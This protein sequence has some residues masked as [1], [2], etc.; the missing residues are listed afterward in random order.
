MFVLWFCYNFTNY[1]IKQNIEVQ[2]PHWISPLWQSMLYNNQGFNI[3]ETCRQLWYDHLWFFSHVTFSIT[4]SSQTPHMVDQ[5]I[6]ASVLLEHLARSLWEFSCS[7]RL[8]LKSWV[9]WTTP[10]QTNRSTRQNI[11]QSLHMATQPHGKTFPS[12][13]TRIR[14]TGTF[15]GSATPQIH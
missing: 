6:P 10:W 3:S 9:R 4:S 11:P 5:P 7:D 8:I 12:R 15:Q 2:Q 13:Y 14:I 1:T